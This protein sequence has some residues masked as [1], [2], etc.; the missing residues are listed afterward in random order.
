M[1]D[2]SRT[3]GTDGM[4]EGQRLRF[5]LHLSGERLLAYYRGRVQSVLVRAHDGR[6]VRLPIQVL[7]PFITREG[8]FGTFEITLSPKG[9]LLD[10]RLVY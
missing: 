6:T 9:K 7:R 4:T 10:I 8:I 5:E 2:T 1:T 3:P